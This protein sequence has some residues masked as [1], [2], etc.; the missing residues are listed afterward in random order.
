[1]QPF[2][3]VLAVAIMWL[4]IIIYLGDT[5]FSR[6]YRM[7]STQVQVYLIS[8]PSKK[9]AEFSI[10]TRKIGLYSILRSG[11]Q[12]KMV[13]RLHWNERFISKGPKHPHYF[14]VKTTLKIKIAQGWPL[15]VMTVTLTLC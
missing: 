13:L 4:I 1:M 5:E 14:S 12:I 8:R 2:I 11:Y 6:W 15:K 9:T 7:F 3:T 10:I